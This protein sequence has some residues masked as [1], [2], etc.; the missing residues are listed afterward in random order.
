MEKVFVGFEAEKIEP[1]EPT[2]IEGIDNE[3]DGH[4]GLGADPKTVKEAE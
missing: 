2:K 3:Y 1:I 4:E